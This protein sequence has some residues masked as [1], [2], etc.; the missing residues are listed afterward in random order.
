MCK[1]R[2]GS[3]G[4]IQYN[5]TKMLSR[6]RTYS[7]EGGLKGVGQGLVDSIIGR[8]KCGGG[9]SIFCSLWQYVVT[10]QESYLKFRTCSYNNVF[11]PSLVWR[12]VW[13]HT[14][15]FSTTFFFT[16]YIAEYSFIGYLCISKGWNDNMNKAFIFD[17]NCFA[18]TA[19]FLPSWHPQGSGQL[20]CVT[21]LDLFLNFD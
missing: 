13:D 11:S 20:L 19:I 14:N 5:N 6:S 21:P 3:L 16:I 10:G 1:T 18:H 7:C 2:F 8:R 17:N 12:H 15:Y 9:I 4:V